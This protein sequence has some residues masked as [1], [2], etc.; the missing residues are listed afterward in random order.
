MRSEGW[1]SKLSEI[2]RVREVTDISGTSIIITTLNQHDLYLY[3]KYL[4]LHPQIKD[5]DKYHLK[6]GLFAAEGTIT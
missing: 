4:S 5:S 2:L 6:N 1:Y 3:F